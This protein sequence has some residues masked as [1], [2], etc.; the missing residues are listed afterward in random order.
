MD[1]QQIER[2]LAE[3]N[4]LMRLYLRY[5][6]VAFAL[7]ALA[8]AV[9]AVLVWK[10]YSSDAAPALVEMQKTMESVQ[11]MTAKTAALL[12]EAEQ[13]LVEVRSV[14]G[15]ITPVLRQAQGTI[16]EV[17]QTTNEVQGVAAPLN[18]LRAIPVLNWFL[19]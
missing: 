3:Q 17:Q 5:I 18:V 1:S 12:E 2:L 9:T 19:Y 7:I 6:A 13:A 10:V 15:A 4:K 16:Q 8:V 11:L 14:T